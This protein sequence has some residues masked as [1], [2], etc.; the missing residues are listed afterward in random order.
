MFYITPPGTSLES[1]GLLAEFHT[2]VRD[3]DLVGF[4]NSDNSWVNHITIYN[5][6]Q[7]I[8]LLNYK[9]N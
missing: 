3:R 9:V 6:K 2:G 1:A 5:A 8:V 4:R 7:Y